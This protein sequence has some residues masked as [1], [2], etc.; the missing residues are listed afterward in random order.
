MERQGEDL[1]TKVVHTDRWGIN[2]RL[3]FYHLMTAFL[4]SLTSTVTDFLRT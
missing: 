2:R 4:I 1:F 3:T